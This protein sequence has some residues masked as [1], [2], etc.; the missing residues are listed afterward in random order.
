MWGVSRLYLAV[1]INWE[2]SRDML[3]RLSAQD[4][5]ISNTLN[6]NSGLQDTYDRFKKMTSCIKFCY[7]G[8]SCLLKQRS[9]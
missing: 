6:S 8:I 1:R 5:A 4:P 7:V 9:R 2:R 3:I